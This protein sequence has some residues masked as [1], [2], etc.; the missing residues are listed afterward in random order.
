MASNV[1]AG[2]LVKLG[3]QVDKDGFA[4]F[5]QAM[6]SSDKSFLLLGKSAVGVGA[7]IASA[8]AGSTIAAAKSVNNLY[9]TAT[10]AGTTIGSLKAAG[11]AFK[12]IGGD[13]G[14]AAQALGTIAARIKSMPQ[15]MESWY[16]G[17][18]IAIRNANGEF[19]DTLAILVELRNRWS[20]MSRPLAEAEAKALGLGA[21]FDDIMNPAF[22]KYLQQA[23]QDQARMGATLDENAKEAQAL[24]AQ[25]DRFKEAGTTAI[26][27]L[28]MQFAKLTGAADLAKSAMDWV[29]NG[30]I[31][32]TVS[33]IIG[34][35]KS[36]VK[37]CGT[38][39]AVLSTIVPGYSQVYDAGEKVA[40]GAKKWY[41]GGA[42]TLNNKQVTS[43]MVSKMS[44]AEYAAFTRTQHG[45]GNPISGKSQKEAVEVL[46]SLEAEVKKQTSLEE[47]QTAFDAEYNAEEKKIN[48][49]VQAAG[50]LWDKAPGNMDGKQ[51]AGGSGAGRP[52]GGGKLVRNNN[53]IAM[54]GGGNGRFSSAE[55]GYG[56]AVRQ[57]KGY[58][59][60]GLRNIGGIL[61]RYASPDAKEGNNTKQYIEF[62]TAAMSKALGQRITARTELDLSD[63]TQLYALSR[64]MSHFES[65]GAYDRML[66]GDTFKQI[67]IEASR[68]QWRSKVVGRQDILRSDGKVDQRQ[69]HNNVR[70][71][72]KQYGGDAEKTAK[73]AAEAVVATGKGAG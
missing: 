65:A 33:G 1:L 53:P 30:G 59:N 25:Y 9:H 72:V 12:A 22:L 2:F 5:R 21:A 27:S 64:A 51:F 10:N 20:Q 56:A 29:I 7:T 70:I 67:A 57:L 60:A 35:F 71:T 3:F 18:G 61:L 49:R 28:L 26:Q 73:I 62:V 4:K 13:A 44:A 24:S 58:W 47:A 50:A 54:G 52:L 39:G 55:E 34:S 66:Q 38:I 48:A 43:Q 6:A 41:L 17:K 19:K 16:R 46:K 42:R 36:L 14:Q 8:I 37:S 15:G 69:I 40:R 45:L 23:A 31:Q 68:S 63:P 11:T 32:K